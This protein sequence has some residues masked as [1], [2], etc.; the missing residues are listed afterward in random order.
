MISSSSLG[1][2]IIAHFYYT[3]LMRGETRLIRK[4]DDVAGAI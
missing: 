4:F 1:I 3:L 2:I